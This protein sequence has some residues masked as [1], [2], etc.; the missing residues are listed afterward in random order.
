V[1][2]EHIVP[3]IVSTCPNAAVPKQHPRTIMHAKTFIFMLTFNSQKQ[4]DCKLLLGRWLGAIEASFLVDLL[5]IPND[6]KLR[7][8]L[9][10]TAFSLSK[11]LSLLIQSTF[12]FTFVLYR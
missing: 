5:I 10:T 3:E 12:G 7:P 8:E 9:I 2:Q 1:S 4:P 6:T 11:A